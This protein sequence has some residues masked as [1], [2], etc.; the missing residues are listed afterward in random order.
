M[1][2]RQEQAKK[3]VLGMRSDLVSMMMPFFPEDQSRREFRTEMEGYAITLKSNDPD[4]A[5][6]T[7]SDRKILNLLAGAVAHNIRAGNPPTRHVAIDTRTIIE[8]ISSDGSGGGSDYQ[9][10][11]ER[12]R[13]LMATVIET[14]MPLGDNVRRRRHFRWIDGFE[15]DDKE[16]PNGRK[17]LGL[18][19]TISEE[20]FLMMTRSLG[21]DLSR[22][23][24][25][26]LTSSR[27]S[28]WRIY[29]ICLAR[30]INNQGRPVRIPIDEL[31]NR[32]P[33]SSELKVFKSRTLR[34]AFDAI[35]QHPEMSKHIQLSLQKRDSGE[36]FE[37]I[38]FTQR[39]KLDKIHVCVSQG[40]APL[41]Q[42]NRILGEGQRDAAH[43]IRGGLPMTRF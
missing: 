20:V 34:T 38:D 7:P 4:I 2:S 29:E 26:E 33:I 41:P 40:E 9:R 6:A 28:I 10:V 37:T 18:R 42:L 39:A 16:L 13:R 5:I 27:S 36:R 19:I 8:N 3:G 11:L 17:M 43:P 1:V 22:Q 21:F 31:R 12:L 15:H 32:V 14:E 30:L 24:F 35:E 25:H 23:S